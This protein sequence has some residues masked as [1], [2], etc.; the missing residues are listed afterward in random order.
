MIDVM[1]DYTYDEIYMDL[2]ETAQ[3][4]FLFTNFRVIG[5]SHDERM[6][7][8][9]EIGKGEKVLFCV[10]GIS[11]TE[12]NNVCMIIKMIKEYC[13]LYERNWE[14]NSLYNVKDLLYKVRICF[15]PILNPDGYEIYRKGFLSIRNPVLRQMLRMQ[16][17]PHKEF[18]RNSRNVDLNDDFPLTEDYLDE[19]CE[20][21]FMKKYIIEN[22][23]RSLIHIMKEY[24]NAGLII[25]G[26]AGGRIVQ[27]RY[28]KKST[29]GRDRRIAGNLKRIAGYRLEADRSNRINDHRYEKMKGSCGE[30]YAKFVRKPAFRIDI[31][32]EAEDCLEDKENI[33][34]MY[35]TIKTIPL[36]F[37]FTI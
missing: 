22:E 18:D 28:Q 17:V 32:Y 15:I 20:N 23:T 16:E 33:F 4:Y 30:Y 34:K 2:W 25:F 7:P 21:D 3:R 37:I 1:N 36:E 10:S 8:M 11:G 35:D 24:K 19:Y 31:P 13:N 14:M 26:N 12:M 6:I 9:F 29:Y 27:Y 5:S